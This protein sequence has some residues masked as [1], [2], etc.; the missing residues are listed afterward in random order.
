MTTTPRNRSYLF[1]TVFVAGMSTLAI[2]FTASRL[3]Q[4][5]Y[6]TSNIVWAN[7]IGLVLLSLTLGYFIGGRLADRR[8]SE[9]LF[10]GLVALAGFCAV[11]FLLLT[12][13]VLRDAAAAMAVMNVGAIAGSLL[14]VILALVVPVT[15]LGCLSPFAIRLAVRD[16][17]E[18]GRISG[19]IYA[20][21]TL[22]SLLGTYLPVLVVIPLAGSRLTA[23]IF[24]ALL[25]G[26]GLIG[27]W[28]SS[29]DRRARAAAL[30]LPVVLLPAAAVW[31]GGGVKS[32]AGQLYETESAYNYIQVI[33]REDCNYLLLNEGQAFHSF[34]CDGGR[35]PE[36]SVWSMMLAAPFFNDP[37]AAP[38]RAA[39]IGLAA[40]TI[41]KQMTRVFG[42]IPIDG[43]ELD[44][45]I[46]D[47]GRR[48]FAMTDP[49]VNAVI[50]DGRYGLGALPGPYDLI[51]VDAY[52]VPYIP[53]H[54]TTREFFLE[55][56]DRLSE[57]GVLA[58]NVGR[59]PGDRRLI[60]AVGATLLSVFPTVHAIDVPGTLNTILVATRQPTTIGN[61][62]ANLAALAP[63]ADSLL[64]D[65]LATAADNLA[66]LG[67]G[68]VVMTDDRA[69]IEIISDSIVIRYLLESGVSG[70]GALGQ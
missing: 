26:V 61:L 59:V 34:Y 40:G 55:V 50:G 69:P 25:L 48:Y 22:G 66:P 1:L 33:R 11:F 47:A 18:A 57:T 38:R 70:L 46:V 23:V 6:G 41:P 29:G 12:G 7:V 58:I 31:L 67:T 9:T 36:V 49:N 8:P 45:A 43:I 17:D 10:Y 13:A 32:Y 4:A 65:A 56:S 64:R 16:V 53:W 15:L 14:L 30:A 60:D 35:V 3:L 19:R 42:P 37:P 2:E 52:K 63:D 62:R 28:R 20:I 51:T 21:S 44:P 54:L 27:L 68:G 39:V 24:G 5:V